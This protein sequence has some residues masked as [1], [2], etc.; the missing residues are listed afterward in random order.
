M[1]LNL[2]FLKQYLVSLYLFDT[3]TQLFWPSQ[4]TDNFR[5][6]SHSNTDHVRQTKR[7]RH[8]LLFF[9]FLSLCLVREVAMT[10]EGDTERA[11]QCSLDGCILCTGLDP[12]VIGR[13]S[14]AVH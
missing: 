7:E 9:S 1:L 13:H 10:P 5:Y 4:K 6:R 14:I 8:V 3:L 12:P 2:V 11:K